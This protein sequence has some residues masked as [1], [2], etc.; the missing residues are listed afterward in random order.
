MAKVTSSRRRYSGGTKRDITSSKNRAA[1]RGS[2]STKTTV[3]R[4]GR[5]PSRA[6]STG[7]SNVTSSAD[8]A[9]RQGSKGQKALPGKPSKQVQRITGTKSKAS[10]PSKGQSGG[11]RPPKGTRAPQDGRKPLTRQ[12]QAKVK[13]SKAAK[14]SSSGRVTKAK[15]GKT[16]TGYSQDIRDAKNLIKQG[17][18]TLG[19]LRSPAQAAG[20][21]LAKALW[22]G[23]GLKG[24]SNMSLLGGDAPTYRKKKGKK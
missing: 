24:S 2:G 4:G 11:S 5:T 12:E 13:Q 15:G 18:K 7:S 10:L 3:G 19:N 16:S 20:G 9:V 21:T 14:G 1:G 8:R 22:D 6:G 17:L 23:R